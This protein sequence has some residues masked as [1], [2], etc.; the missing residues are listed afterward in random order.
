MRN[1]YHRYHRPTSTSE[2]LPPSPGLSPSFPPGSVPD[3]MI[4]PRQCTCPS[5]RPTPIASTF[6]VFFF[7][8]P[9]RLASI[10][11]DAYFYSTTIAA[12]RGGLP[13]NGVDIMTATIFAPLP[14]PAH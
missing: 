3:M 11:F 8:F 12:S 5:A 10:L 1:H 13:A 7:G 6:L 4:C 14:S 2:L 9:Q